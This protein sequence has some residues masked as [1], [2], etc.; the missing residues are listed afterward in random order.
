MELQGQFHISAA[1]TLGQEL[2]VPIGQEA[3]WTTEMIWRQQCI[4]APAWIWTPVVKSITSC[5]VTLL[6]N[7]S[8]N[9]K[10]KVCCTGME[11]ASAINRHVQQWCIVEFSKMSLE[12]LYMCVASCGIKY[13]D[14][15]IWANNRQNSLNIRK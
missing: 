10:R 9:M 4:S 11:F 14:Y 8:W 2:L 1:L 15:L 5:L 3:I 7:L 13:W 12:I 6:T